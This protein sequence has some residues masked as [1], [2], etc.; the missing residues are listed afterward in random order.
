MVLMF[1]LIQLEK[2]YGV[3]EDSKTIEFIK[4]I[5]QIKKQNRSTYLH[6]IVFQ[7]VHIFV[8]I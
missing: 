2:V 7:I 8:P 3:Y 6:F 1:P 4:K 5:N